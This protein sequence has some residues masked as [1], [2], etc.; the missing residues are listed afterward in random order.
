[1]MA[2]FIANIMMEP[3]SL[4]RKVELK[5]ELKKMAL[6]QSCIKLQKTQKKVKSGL[7]QKT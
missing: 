2:I 5:L 3:K 1:M 7:K 6:L 4:H